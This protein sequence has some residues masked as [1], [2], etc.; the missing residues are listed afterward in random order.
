MDD[1]YEVIKSE[2][3]AGIHVHGDNEIDA[4][5][6]SNTIKEFATITKETALYIDPDAYVRINVTAFN[7]GSFEIL[8]NAIVEAQNKISFEQVSAVTSMAATTI[9]AVKG[10]FDIRKLL[11]GEKPKSVTENNGQ[12]IVEN[13]AGN[14]VQAPHASKIVLDNSVVD[15]SVTNI[16]YNL[17][18][19]HSSSGFSFIANDVETEF[20]QQDVKDMVSGLPRT[21]TSTR[22]HIVTRETLIIKKPDMM[23]LSAWDLHRDGK[24]IKAKINDEAWLE[25]I[26]HREHLFGYGDA[27]EVDLETDVLLDEIQRPIP[28]SERYTVNNVIRAVTEYEQTTLL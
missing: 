18:Q 19:H 24:T 15:N 21:E 13:N 27:I 2:A 16:T 20:T 5:I 8:F 12:I 23:G 26:K 1:A 28:N 25:S 17:M 22:K 7:N 10:I 9:T 11:K 4:I 6:L 3:K 14:I